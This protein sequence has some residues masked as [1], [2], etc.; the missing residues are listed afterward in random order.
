MDYKIIPLSERKGNGFNNLTGEKFG[1]LTVLGL[2]ERKSGRKSF[3]VC[4]CTC[5]KTLEV[6]SDMLKR[7]NTKSCGCLKKEQDI[8]NLHITDNHGLSQTHLYRKWRSMLNRCYKSNQENYNRY[9]GRGIIVCKDWHDLY[10]FIEWAQSTGY[11]NGLSIERIDNDGNYCPENCKWVEP[12]EQHFNKRT[13]VF[14]EYQGERLTT[15]QWQR[16]LGIPIKIVETYRK[17]NINF[18]DIIKK[19]YKDDTEVN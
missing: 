14:H 9:G 16:K 8:K 7:G 5:G 2:S 6:R 10:N 1:R 4:E 19:Y 17:K 18:V 15:M 11:K 13:S 3:W 12:H